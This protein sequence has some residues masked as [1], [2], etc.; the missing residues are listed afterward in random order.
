MNKIDIIASGKCKPASPF[1]GILDM[2]RQRLDMAF[3]IIEID[4]RKGNAETIKKNEN[5][6]ILN[7]LRPESFKIALDE[8]GQT[9]TSIAFANKIR[10]IA[11]HRGQ[12][13]FQFVIGGA[14]GLLPTVREKCDFL[15]SF[16]R[17]TWPHMMVRVMLVE[18]IYRTQQ[19]LKGHPYHR[20]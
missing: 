2:Y 6:Q 1:F 4:I 19:I 5:E 11:T 14:D 8:D 3:N 13:H 16:G 17:Q 7:F 18:Q 12:S 10:D 15:L 20:A 9:V